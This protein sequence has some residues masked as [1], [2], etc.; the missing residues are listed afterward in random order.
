MAKPRSSKF[1]ARLRN[2]FHSSNRKPSPLLIHPFLQRITPKIQGDFSERIESLSDTQIQSEIMSVL[3]KMYPRNDI[4]APL[5][6]YFERW[7]K[8]PRF[9]GSYSN[10]LPSFFEERHKNVKK[11]VGRVWFAGEHT[12]AK[13]FG[14]LHGA[15]IEGQNV[16]MEVGRCIVDG[17]LY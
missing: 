13:H 8:N 3:S 5:D 10:W 7:H 4:P 1:H 17:C 16:A 14:F 6:F 9:Y 11:R 12:S 15:Y 2:P